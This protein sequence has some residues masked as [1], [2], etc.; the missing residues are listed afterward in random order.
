MMTEAQ[1]LVAGYPWSLSWIINSQ[2]RSILTFVFENPGTLSV[3]LEGGHALMICV[4]AT[5]PAIDRY[6][7]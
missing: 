1:V 5:T 2:G 3:V 4:A 6:I 7:K